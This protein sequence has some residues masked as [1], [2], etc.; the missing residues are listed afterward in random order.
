VENW[1]KETRHRG[2]RRR[3]KRGGIERKNKHVKG[4]ERGK[5]ERKKSKKSDKGF[6]SVS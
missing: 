2:A 6:P 3:A 4:K 5:F 1:E